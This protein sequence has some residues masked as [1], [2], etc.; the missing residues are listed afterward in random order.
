MLPM[1]SERFRD[2]RGILFDYGGTLDGDGDHWLDRF[3]QL[4]RDFRL[5]I[6]ESEIKRVFY[7]ADETCCS[8]PEVNEIGL[9]P[10]MKLHVRRQFDA[11][12]MDEDGLAT[13]L[14]S[15]FCRRSE[16]FMSRNAGLLKSLRERF[17]LGVVSNFYGN[18]PIICRDGGLADSLDTILD[19]TLFGSG[20]PDPEIF[21]AALLHLGLSPSEVFFVG[22]SYERDMIPARRLGMK[23]VW[24]KGPNPR[25]P[26]NAGPVDFCITNL[27]QLDSIFS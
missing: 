10:L 19:S 13:D 21:L 5:Q 6:P 8:D 1:N 20:K 18:V 23:T 3:Y 9:R 11:L 27:T 25:K 15:A 16:R 24:L 17:R 26:S 4:Y 22:D 7:L 12:G 2:C 14:A